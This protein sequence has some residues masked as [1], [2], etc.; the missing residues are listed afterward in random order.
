MCCKWWKK[1]VY[2][3]YELSREVYSG[4]GVLIKNAPELNV[5]NL[6]VLDNGFDQWKAQKLLEALSGTKI[7]GFTFVNL[8]LDVNYHNREASDFLLN[9]APIKALPITSSIQWRDLKM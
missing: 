5:L 1:L 4:I 6:T 3:T 7:T 9:M 2:P 8:A